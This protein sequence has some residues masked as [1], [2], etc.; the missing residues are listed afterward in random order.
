VQL[1]SICM[2]TVTLMFSV[3]YLLVIKKINVFNT[4]D[5][6]KLLYLNRH[7]TRVCQAQKMQWSPR[8][9]DIVE[10]RRLWNLS[11][12]ILMGIGKYESIL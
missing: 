6:I 12:N 7:K 8:E 11:A 3:Y 9:A 1:A 5:K 10:C 4:L 2:N